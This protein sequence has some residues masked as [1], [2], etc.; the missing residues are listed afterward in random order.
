MGLFSVFNPFGFFGF[1]RK[2]YAAW[3]ALMAAYTYEHLS[4][5]QQETITQKALEIESSVRGRHVLFIE[6]IA[7]MSEAQ[8]Y[9]LYSLAMMNLEIRPAIGNELWFEVKNP[10]VDLLNAKEVIASTKHQLEKKYGV[11]FPNISA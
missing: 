8:R 9:H 4:P 3:N 2:Y 7:H 6:L 1:S 11:R 5:D 10:H